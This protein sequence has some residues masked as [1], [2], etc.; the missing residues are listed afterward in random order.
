MSH[1]KSCAIATLL[2]ASVALA[3]P[4]GLPE[5]E[6]ERLELNPNGR[7]SLLMGTGELLPTG[8]FR[9]SLLGQYENDPLVM[10]R[11]DNRLGSVVK[12]RVTAHLLAAWAPLQ[13]LE[14]GAQVPLVVWQGGEDLSAQGVGKL[15]R[16]GLSTPTAYARVGLLA[17]R[18]EAPLDLALELGVGLPVGS[19]N[20]LSK[21]PQVRFSPRVMAGRRFGWLRAGVDVGMLVRPSVILG[22]EGDVRDELGNEFRLGAVLATTGGGL[23][24]EL[25]ARAVLPVTREPSSL[26]LLAGLRYP[27]GELFEAYALGGPGFGDTPGTPTFRVLLGVAFA[28]GEQRDDDHDGVRN[29]EDACPKEA[30]PAE[31]K[32][33]PWK[34]ADGDGVE[35][36]EDKCPKEPGPAEL[37]GCPERDA[38]GD[39]IENGEDACPKEAGPAERKGCPVRDMDGDGIEDGSDACPKEAGPAERKGCPVKDSDGDG[40]VD[41][42][43]LCPNEAGLLELRGCPPKD[44]D[45]DTVSDHLDNC[46]NEKGPP[47]NQGCPEK[48]KQL[49]AIEKGRLEIKEQ[50]FFDTAKST[51]RS[52]SFK[53]LD[54]VARV[55]KEHP[56][57]E[58]VII[59]GHTDSTGSAEF[60]R[61]LSQARAE[62]VMAYLVNRGVEPARLE[63]KGYGPDRPIAS[64]ETSR[65]RAV[66]RRVA[67]I[68]PP[69]SESE[70]K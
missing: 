50:V 52:R 22:D 41:E 14:L 34:D 68:I 37:M 24:G 54:Q 2:L 12:D 44:T 64:N 47:A 62:S 60:N 69:P 7:G 70:L 61:K 45:G 3:Q 5:F 8:A 10:Y 21:D 49:V 58:K 13:W 59:E 55:I 27:L 63:A 48:E 29:E 9:L 1:A 17:Q 57:I 40:V 6:L 42:R 66:N 16:T 25:N 67:F 35:D 38:D 31:R 4:A 19:A 46:P 32:G 56:E 36:K 23:R 26:E 15:E 28:G 18:R 11:D 51:I 20:T 65:G 33:C 30:G 43:D 53:M 39:G